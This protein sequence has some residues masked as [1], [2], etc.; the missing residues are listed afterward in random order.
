[1]EDTVE[2]LIRKYDVTYNDVVK[3]VELLSGV[4]L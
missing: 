2:K 3:T 4:S 1:M